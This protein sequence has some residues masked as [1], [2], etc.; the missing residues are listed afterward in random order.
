MSIFGMQ[1]CNILGLAPACQPG[2]SIVE[3]ELVSHTKKSHKTEVFRKMSHPVVG[4]W[5]TS[6]RRKGVRK[7]VNQ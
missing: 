6:G 7:W 1:R 5:Q 4:H 3:T 2:S